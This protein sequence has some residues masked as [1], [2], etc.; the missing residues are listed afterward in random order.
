MRGLKGSLVLLLFHQASIRGQPVD[1]DSDPNFSGSGE[2]EPGLVAIDTDNDNAVIIDLAPTTEKPKT[3]NKN[4]AYCKNSCCTY[5]RQPDHIRI[6]PIQ[7]QENTD[8]VCK[9]IPGLLQ[10]GGAPVGD[11]FGEKDGLYGP[12]PVFDATTDAPPISSD[13]VGMSL[14]TV[15]AVL[16][17]NF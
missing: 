2:E 13:V 3:I 11:Y 17:L 8:C 16:A 6:D 9:L 7:F 14:A 10:C 15:L 12:K 5:L 4:L 1:S